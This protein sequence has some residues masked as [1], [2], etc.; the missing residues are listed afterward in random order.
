MPSGHLQALAFCLVLVLAFH[1]QGRY[2]LVTIPDEAIFMEPAV[3]PRATRVFRTD[4]AVPPRGAVVGFEHPAHA[5]KLLL[6]RAAG[7]PGDRV[8]VKAGRLVLS[9]KPQPEDHAEKR[10]EPEDLAEI[11]VPDGHV[12][13]L[14]DARG[15]AGSPARDS[16]RLG[17][18]P[19]A[20][21][22]GWLADRV[23]ERARAD[24]AAGARR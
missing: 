7:V 5:G 3:R 12:Y 18:I 10:V 11:V 2:E 4:G 16:R 15:E 14:N 21:V 17:P 6:S 8:A 9:G 20:S 13:V 24:E 22:V 23:A 1:V 19:A